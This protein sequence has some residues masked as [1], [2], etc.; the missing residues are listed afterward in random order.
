LT[1]GPV[2][3][4]ARAS[5]LDLEARYRDCVIGGP[6][7]FTMT[8]NQPEDFSSAIRQK[9]LREIALLRVQAAAATPG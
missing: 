6:G 8:G 7:A 1:A 5:D 9:L 2:G 3:R 4:K